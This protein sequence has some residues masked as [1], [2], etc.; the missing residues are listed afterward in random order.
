MVKD[1][2]WYKKEMGFR[3]DRISSLRCMNKELSKV[4]DSKDNKIEGLRLTT[5]KL[6]AEID[7]KDREIT[8]IIVKHASYEEVNK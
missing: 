3:D 8:S 7:R 5:N 6:L 1:V 4:I 2:T